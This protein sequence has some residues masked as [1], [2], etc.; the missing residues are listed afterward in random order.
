VAD[1]AAQESVRL[2]VDRV[3]VAQPAFVVD[4]DNA[5]A[6]GQ[7]CRQL[8][9]IPLALELAAARARQMSVATLASRIGDRFKLLTNG[10]RSALPRQQTLRALIDWSHDLL[11]EPERALFRRL[12]VF[13]GGWTLEAAEAVCGTSGI[14]TSAGV[15]VL[16]LIG[17]LVDKSLVSIDR[18]YERYRML[19]TVRQ[20][21]QQ[22][23]VEAGESGPLRRA[24]LLT[25]LL[26]AERLRA[27]MDGPEQGAC[28]ETLDLEREN[29]L[30]CHAACDQEPDGADLGVRLASAMRR[31]CI[32]RGLL[33][34][35]MRLATEALLRLPA[36]RRDTVRCNA[37]FDIGQLC[38]FTGHY[39]RARHYLDEVLELARILG[40]R[41]LEFDSSAVLGMCLLG[42]KELSL[43]ERSLAHAYHMAREL[44]QSGRIALAANGLAQCLRM[45]GRWHDAITYNEETARLASAYGDRQLT[46]I[47]LLNLAMLH[48]ECREPDLARL[49]LSE[50]AALGAVSASPVLLQSLFEAASG[51]AVCLLQWDEALH[52]LAVAQSLAVSNG[53]QRDPADEVFVAYQLDAVKRELGEQQFRRYAAELASCGQPAN[54]LLCRLQVWLD[55]HASRGSANSA[56]MPEGAERALAPVSNAAHGRARSE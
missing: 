35:G 41:E 43:A 37:L 16:D 7:I 14:E 34:L 10:D 29:L 2:F 31:Y 44:G 11:S 4:E 46:G 52:C 55:E 39:G 15:D 6:V 32:D 49:R 26:E 50:T 18:K 13:A 22:R 8:D 12:S 40:D 20:Y 21:A 24:H 23:L 51:L 25:Y 17:G 36:S 1:V 30:V 5:L 38:Y 33:G 42:L 53:L 47:A 45:Q 54:D 3:R 48:V 27:G 28:I 9:G 56:R 19:E